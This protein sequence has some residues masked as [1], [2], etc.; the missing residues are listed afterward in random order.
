MVKNQVSSL[1]GFTAVIEGVAKQNEEARI[2]V[3]QERGEPDLFVPDEDAENA[4]AGF[5]VGYWRHGVI[6]EAVERKANGFQRY[7]FLILK[8]ELVKQLAKLGE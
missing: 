5:G 1:A 4:T 2:Q 6:I 3:E 8:V 7:P